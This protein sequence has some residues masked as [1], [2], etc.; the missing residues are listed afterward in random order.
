VILDLVGPHMKRSATLRKGFTLIELLVVIAIIAILIGLLLPAVQKVR[1][2]AN[3]TQ[4]RNNLKQMGLGC[5]THHDVYKFLPSGGEVWSAGNDRSWANGASSSG[6]GSAP[7]GSVPAVYDTQVWGWM[8]QLLPYIEQQNLWSDLNDGAVTS[9][10]VMTYLCP[11]VGLIRFDSGYGA[12]NTS[13]RAMNDYLGNGGTYGWQQF[14][15]PSAALDG[16]IVPSAEMCHH[17]KRLT[18]LTDGT[19]VTLLVG[20]K[21]LPQ[22]VWIGNPNGPPCNEDQGYT[23]G[24][25]NDT[26]GFGTLGGT[27]SAALTVTPQR[28]GPAY[29]DPTLPGATTANGSVDCGTIFGSIHDAGCHFVFC[30]G[31]VHLIS[32]TIDTTTFANLISGTDGNV[33]GQEGW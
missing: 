22:S 28:F 30:D 18:D 16:P 5:H 27:S 26:I 3:R 32:F 14:T 19:S 9:Q 10:H 17:P 13:L 1:E 25:D 4:C 29:P 6:S 11:S 33:I 23:D 7:A 24:W 2:A 20:E 12:A 21:W 31:S 15:M 8:Y